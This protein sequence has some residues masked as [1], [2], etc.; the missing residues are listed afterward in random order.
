M[1]VQL[2]V[3]LALALFFMTPLSRIVIAALF[4]K[5]IGKT[6]LAKQPDTIRLVPAEPSKLRKAEQVASIAGEYQ[7]AG[8][9]S[10][11]VFS[12]PELPG[13]FVQLLANRSESMGAAIYDHPIAG[14]FYDVFS[15]YVGGGSWTHTSARATGL[16]R[17]DNQKVVNLP[18]ANAT[19]LIER[20]RRERS[21]GGLKSCAAAMVP[22]E[23]IAAYAE[24]MT[25]MK[26]RG[27]S[28]Q[29]VVKVATRKAA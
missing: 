16:K 4:G 29:E 20:A 13:L 3:L 21:P 17:P 8:F 14:V 23:F 5:A 18:G 19:T 2:I 27:I 15:R 24:Q 28:T 25:W 26:Q 11:G 9:E 7:R 1:P 10:A 6:A 12:V 22:V